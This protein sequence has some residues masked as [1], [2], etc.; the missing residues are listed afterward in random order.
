MTQTTASVREDFD[1]IARLTERNGWNHNDHY[2]DFLLRYVPEH[3]R[4]A[5]DIGCGTG[6]FTRR[7]ARRAER[8]IGI[9]LSPEMVRMARESSAGY[10]N[11]EYRVADVQEWEPAE[12]QF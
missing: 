6:A 9:D 5:L 8:A 7:L 2:H 4:N 3:C 12:A 1:R 10:P 11:A